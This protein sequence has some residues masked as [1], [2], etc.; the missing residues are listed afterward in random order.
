MSERRQTFSQLEQI[1][2]EFNRI[3]TDRR[4]KY[5]DDATRQKIMA[6]LSAT[7]NKQKSAKI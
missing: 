5:D 1:E 6:A 7:Q 2:E 4:S 3:G